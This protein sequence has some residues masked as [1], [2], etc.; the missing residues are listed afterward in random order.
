MAFTGNFQC[1]ECAAILRELMAALPSDFQD[2]KQSWLASGR[3][4]GELRDEMFAGFA[5][6][7]SPDSPLEHY[8]R[9][10][11]A[12]RRLAEHEALTGHSVFT[13]GLRIALHGPNF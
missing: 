9:T 12:R 7:D 2:L 11:A 4:L 6:D 8:P 1:A 13:H 3:D 10:R 5:Q